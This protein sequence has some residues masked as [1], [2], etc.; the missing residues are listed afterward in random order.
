MIAASRARALVVIKTAGVAGGYLVAIWC[1]HARMVS[2]HISSPLL[3]LATAA[4]L[5]QS[6]AIG[7]LVTT[8]IGR[9]WMSEIQERRA[10]RVQPSMLD[11]LAAHAAGTDRFA[12][13]WRWYRHHPALVERCLADILS[14]IIGVSRDRLSQL[15]VDVGVVARWRRQCR[16]RRVTTRRTAIAYLGQLSGGAGVP[17]LLS[18]LDDPEP[19]IRLDAARNTLRSGRRRTDVESVFAFAIRASLLGRMIL[20][21]ELRAHALILS[22][23]AIPDR[24]RS[25]DRD[26]ILIVLEMIEAWG[27]ALPLPDIVTLVRHVDRDIRVRALRVLLFVAGTHDLQAEILERLRDE[28]PSVRAAAAFA[29]GRLM[30]ESADGL[31]ADCLRDPH[32]EVALGA[33]FALAELGPI[34]VGVLEREIASPCR[35]AAVAALEALERVKIG[36]CDYARR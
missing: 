31:L 36:R 17:A 10:R 2:A 13:L 32:P 9:R 23:R 19:E 20:A 8:L 34:G 11:A 6:S 12:D 5:V 14:T 28:D 4:A 18:A 25:G 24:L 16:S 26:Q 7:L 3:S 15:A 30:V 22:E 21:D 33:G 1:V 27:R 29:A 35:P